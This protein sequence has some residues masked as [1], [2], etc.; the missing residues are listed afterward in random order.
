MKVTKDYEGIKY[1]S[2][3]LNEIEQNYSKGIFFDSVRI[4]VEKPGPYF[5]LQ[6][7]FYFNKKETSN[8]KISIQPD[9]DTLKKQLSLENKMAEEYN[10]KLETCVDFGLLK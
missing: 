1:L 10:F 7:T 3:I 4:K 6:Y 9:K 8:V 5:E 2:E